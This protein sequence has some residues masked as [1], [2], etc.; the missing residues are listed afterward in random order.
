M[1]RTNL[2]LFLFLSNACNLRCKG[3][4][5]AKENIKSLTLK[6]IETI[7][8]TWDFDRVGILGGEPLLIKNLDKIVEM[9]NKPVTIYT[10]GTLLT[11]DKIIE[12]VIYAVSLESLNEKV[13]DSIRGKGVYKKVMNAL[14]I[15][16]K[17]RDRIKEIIIRATYNSRNYKDMFEL[18]EFCEQN[19]IG[20]AMHPRIGIEIYR[21]KP[22]PSLDVRQQLELFTEVAKR[23]KMVVLTPHFF[24]WVGRKN[25][26]CPA[27]EF[28]LAVAENGN[29]K[30]C[31]WGEYVV[32]NVRTHDFD[33]IRE[34]GI[35]YNRNFVQ[36]RF[37]SRCLY[38]DRLAKCHGGCK[39]INDTAHCP[40]RPEYGYGIGR[41]L[42]GKEINNL[43]VSIKRLGS[44]GFS[45]C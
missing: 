38:C 12:N 1:S 8:T 10:N 42:S 24:Q 41:F 5:V 28:R 35:E 39:L 15:L 16:M 26:R 6:D 9:L 2:Q 27:G 36:N 19:D 43:R 32:G 45:G 25:Y 21:G 20:L 7:A 30:P 37:P 3:C 14:D 4:P 33:L 29:V 13:N 11:E 40:L 23:S 18:I 34:L 31:Q 17:N 22:I 44:I